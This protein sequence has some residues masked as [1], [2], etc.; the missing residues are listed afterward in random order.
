M[1]T[2]IGIGADGMA[3][4]AMP[5]R[6]ELRSAT[7]V[8]GSPRQLGMLDDTVTADRRQWSS[9]MLDMV[10]TLRDFSGDVHVLASGD[11]HAARC[12][13]VADQVVRSGQGAGAAARVVGDTG[14]RPA[15]LVRAGHRGVISLMM[16]G[17]HTAVR[18]GGQAVVL[19]RNGREPA[20]LARLLARDRAW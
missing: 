13:R 17:P 7:V 9:P 12:R 6:D 4:L 14:L 11:P 10:A 5:S 3:G 16:A 2:V 1:I 19:T 18:R 15:R 8:Y 20:E